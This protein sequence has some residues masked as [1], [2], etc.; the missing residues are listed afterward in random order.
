MVFPFNSHLS[1]TVGI[2]LKSNKNVEGC[3]P[4]ETYLVVSSIELNGFY[5]W[6][7]MHRI[8]LKNT[9]RTPLDKLILCIYLNVNPFEQRLCTHTHLSYIQ[10]SPTAW[11]GYCVHKTIVKFHIY[12]YPGLSFCVTIL[13]STEYQHFFFCCPWQPF[14]LTLTALL[15]IYENWHIILFFTKI[16]KSLPVYILPFPQCSHT[17]PIPQ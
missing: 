17:F 1:T 7:D 6:A 12:S 5:S 4:M 14:V 9:K 16:R 13:T 11:F 8:A 3:N 2:S 15:S 10:C